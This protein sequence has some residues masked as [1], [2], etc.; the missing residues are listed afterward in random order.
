[1]DFISIKYLF[2]QFFLD[3]IRNNQHVKPF[4]IIASATW[5][6]AFITE[7]KNAW[8]ALGNISVT[9]QCSKCYS[10]YK[11]SSILRYNNG[12]IAYPLL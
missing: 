11:I 7:R 12:Y 1:M 9:S 6:L 3:R 5:Y 2:Y 4:H 8:A 10:I